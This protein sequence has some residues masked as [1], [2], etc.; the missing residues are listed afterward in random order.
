MNSRYLSVTAALILAQTLCDSRAEAG[1]FPHDSPEATLTQMIGLA[2][3]EVSYSRPRVRGRKIWDGLVPFGRV[4]RTGAN[5][6]TFVTVER[7]VKVE[8]QKLAPG[9]YALY[10]IPGPREWT[11]IFSTNTELWGAYGYQ[12]DDDALRVRVNPVSASFRESFTIEVS[13]VR[14]DSAVLNLRWA[15]LNVPIT[16]EQPIYDEL[17]SRIQAEL[18]KDEEKDWGF[19]WRSAKYVLELDGDLELAEKWISESL[20]RKRT[21]MNVWTRAELSAAKQRLDRAVEH[22]TEALELCR[23]APTD[24]PYTGVYKN[25]VDTWRAG[26]SVESGH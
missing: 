12:P 17:L 7:E 16:I 2:K 8:G 26:V 4:W 19:Y 11:V 25:R 18:E 14:L 24:C 22:A 15:K 6:P 21:W 20:E 9:K 13:D 1:F 3:I 23:A 5:Y 10:T